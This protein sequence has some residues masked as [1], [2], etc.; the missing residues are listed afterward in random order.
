M[1]K[2]RMKIGIFV[3]VMGLTALSVIASSSNSQSVGWQDE[4]LIQVSVH[5]VD[6]SI[7]WYTEVLGWEL[8]ERWDD[9][10]WARIIMPD[11]TILGLGQAPEGAPT[12]SGSMSL[13]VT[14]A[15]IDHA[16]K[17]LEARGATFDG[18]TLTIPDV[19]RLA[20]ITDENGIRIRLAQDID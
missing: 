6:S 10:T 5:D 15:D 2:I 17:M 16:R 20:T 7:E 8:E 1:T 19:V 14:V 18:P 11:S 3:G 4:L 9:G 13:N 12:G